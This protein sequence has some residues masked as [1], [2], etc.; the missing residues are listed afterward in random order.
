[1]NLK[2]AFRYQNKIQTLIA[3]VQEIL[4]DEANITKV[5]NTHLRSKVMPEVG[6][7]TVCFEP[8]TEYAE[9]ITDVVRFMLFLLSEKEKLF[10]AIRKAK[11]EL[12]IDVDIEVSLNNVR[13]SV[14]HTLDKMNQIRCSERIITGG[15][16]GYRFNADGNQVTYRCDVKRVITINYDRKVIRTELTKLNKASD[17]V[18]AQI[19][20]CFVNSTV[21]Y[22]PLFDV[23]DNFNAVFEAFMEKVG[24]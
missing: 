12:D 19:D 22:E 17:A 7:E 18:S 10:A 1:M 3:A 20:L 16:T 11:N 8:A 9:Q 15:G 14:A 5:E 4:E 13:Q 2:E 21:D 24:A 23:N 6:D